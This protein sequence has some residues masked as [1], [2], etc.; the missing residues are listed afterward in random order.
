MDNSASTSEMVHGGVCTDF[1]YYDSETLKTQCFPTTQNTR[2]T[3][4]FQALAGG[5]NTFTIPPNNGL[6]QVCVTAS[7]PAIASLSEGVGLST[8]WLYQAIDSIT[9]RYGGSA[10]F[11]INGL[12]ALQIALRQ[13]PNRTSMNDLTTLG[14]TAVKGAELANGVDA[15]II[16]PLPHSSCSGVGKLHPFPTDILTQQCVIQVVLKPISSIWS[17]YSGSALPAGCTQFSSASFVAQQILLNNQGDSLSRRTDM[18]RSAYSF[19]TEFNQQL[20]TV[21]LANSAG[22]QSVTINGLRFGECKSLQIWLTRNTD[23]PAT[24]TT[25]YLYN[26]LNWYLPTSV[27]LTYAGDI[28]AQ[29]STSSLAQLMNL[30]NGNKAPAFS[31]TNYTGASATLTKVPAT[32][33][34]LELPFSQP[35]VDE[36]NHYNLI[37]GK[38]LT[39]GQV[40]LALQTPSAQADWVLNVAPVYVTHLIMSQGTSEYQF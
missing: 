16:L 36:D 27:V 31:I 34:F 22:V 14:G 3:Q 24:V 39:N 40:Q 7:F 37:H 17:N 1:Y 35:N 19:P 11:S 4:G 21:A 12:Q 18:S 9:Y 13:Q 20:I 23:T 38:V 2:F 15:S 30:T 29:Y 5:T 32:G 6:Q 25:S 26:P 8:G 10:Q 28:Y 33:F